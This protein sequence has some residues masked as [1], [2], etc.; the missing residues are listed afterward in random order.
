MISLPTQYVQLSTHFVQRKYYD[1][2]INEKIKHL[3]ELNQLSQEDMAQRLHLSTSGY[4]KIEKGERGLD[5]IKLE[6]I[7][8]IFNLEVSD[9]LDRNVICLLNENSYNHSNNNLNNH[10]NYGNQE[11]GAQI[12]KLTLQLTYSQ[13]II[14][15]KDNEIAALKEVIALLKQNAAK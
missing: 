1:M 9:L 15:Q 11:L 12:E 13:E 7:A 3:R 8:A 10:N 6:K 14:M 4:A 5:L 2:T